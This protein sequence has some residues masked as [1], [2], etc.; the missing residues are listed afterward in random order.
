MEFESSSDL[1]ESNNPAIRLSRLTSCVKSKREKW[2]LLS[3]I[4]SVLLAVIF[5]IALIVV[6]ERSLPVNDRPDVCQSEVCV[7]ISRNL[8]SYIDSSVDPCEDFYAY[9]CGK[10]ISSYQ[11]PDTS[12]ESGPIVSS[13][14]K[15]NSQIRGKKS[16]C[17]MA[18]KVFCT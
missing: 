13:Q 4:V 5:M 7:N 17:L 14:Q 10:W 2:L 1:F 6:S 3:L 8:Y 12:L 16:E 15:I 9:T 11:L 18:G